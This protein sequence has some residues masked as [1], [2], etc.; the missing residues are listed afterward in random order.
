VVSADRKCGVGSRVCRAAAAC[1]ELQ[2][3]VSL[4]ESDRARQEQGGGD[5]GR[6]RVGVARGRGVSNEERREGAEWEGSEGLV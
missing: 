4:L 3:A 5:K 6:G 1:V 2:A